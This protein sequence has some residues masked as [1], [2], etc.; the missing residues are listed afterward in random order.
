MSRDE[1]K[2]GMKTR[3]QGKSIKNKEKIALDESAA[4]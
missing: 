2:K 4:S 3:K 1:S